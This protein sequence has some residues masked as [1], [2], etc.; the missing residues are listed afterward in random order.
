VVHGCEWYALWQGERVGEK[1][2][3]SRYALSVCDVRVDACRSQ[4]WEAVL[5]HARV[6]LCKQARDWWGRPW[7]GR[8]NY[9]DGWMLDSFV[10][11]MQGECGWSGERDR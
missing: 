9:G 8:D 3:V 11:V 5:S 1:R 4:G 10:V 2:N 7:G 6:K